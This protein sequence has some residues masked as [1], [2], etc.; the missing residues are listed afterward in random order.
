L[1]YQLSLLYN[2][3]YRKWTGKMHDTSCYCY[4][5]A[6]YIMYGRVQAG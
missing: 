2:G 4:L 5:Y 3:H 1:C 6:V